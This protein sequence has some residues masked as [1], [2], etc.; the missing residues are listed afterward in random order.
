MHPEILF[1][2]F[3]FSIIFSCT[4]NEMFAP[5]LGLWLNLLVDSVALVL[6]LLG[7]C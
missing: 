2:F 5:L 6:W 3:S 4:A 1:L 7:Y